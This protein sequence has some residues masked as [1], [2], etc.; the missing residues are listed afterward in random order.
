MTSRSFRWHTSL[1]KNTNACIIQEKYFS[2]LELKYI[3]SLTITARKL[4]VVSA[5]MAQRPITT[6][7]DDNN[8]SFYLETRIQ[9]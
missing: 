8:H 7:N 1:F 5:I 3:I 2:E 4:L 6:L 9:S